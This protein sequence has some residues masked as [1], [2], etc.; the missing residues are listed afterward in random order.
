MRVMHGGHFWQFGSIVS[1][2]T[3]TTDGEILV[4]FLAQTWPQ[5]I[6]EYIILK[7]FLG[8]YAPRP[9]LACSHLSACNGRT[10]LK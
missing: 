6:S 2:A 3:E 1:L 9:S 8:E 10:S 5:A 4:A 7:N